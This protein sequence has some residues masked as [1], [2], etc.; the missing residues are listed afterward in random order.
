MENRRGEF[1]RALYSQ[2]SCKVNTFRQMRVLFF[3]E[4]SGGRALYS[5]RLG[6]L[7]HKLH[8]ITAGHPMAVAPVS[9]LIPNLIVRVHISRE[10]AKYTGH[11]QAGMPASGF[12]QDHLPD[13]LFPCP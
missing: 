5:G 1:A 6:T 9:D 3:A 11:T 7:R 10:A 2:L 13:K 4:R 12:R 8:Y